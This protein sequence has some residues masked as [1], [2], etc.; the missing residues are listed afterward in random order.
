MARWV[1][2]GADP[3]KSKRIH[4]V[5]SRVYNRVKTRRGLEFGGR[6]MRNDG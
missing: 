2:Q 5:I 4:A 6:L 3:A 1:Q